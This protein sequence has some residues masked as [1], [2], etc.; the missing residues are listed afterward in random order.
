MADPEKRLPTGV[1]FDIKRCSIKDGPGLRTSVFLKGCPLRCAWCHNPE[2]WALEPQA[3]LQ[4][5]VCGRVMSVEEVMAEVLPDEP[6]Y[7]RSGGGLT[8]SGGEPMFQP[9]FARALAE[10]AHSDGI[11]VALD[12]SGEA[13]WKEYERI[14][15]FVDLFLYD[16]KATGI[17][18]HRRLI[19]TDGVR[20][21]DNLRRLGEAGARLRLRC[22]IAQ[23][24]NDSGE[25]RRHV[26]TLAAT[27]PGVE[28]VDWLPY[29]P[30]GQEKYARFGI[31]PREMV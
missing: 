21:L 22:P 1:V 23:G 8:V 3:D 6:F 12:T 28:G 31:V 29:H 2:S 19:G 13:P 5:I 25:H 18:L 11:R 9:D 26:E 14:L 10:A 16:V 30:L 4:G 17:E 27:V 15:P 24:V 20:I 7:N